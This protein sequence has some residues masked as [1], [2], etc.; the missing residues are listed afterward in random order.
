MCLHLNTVIDSKRKSLL[1]KLSVLK[2]F[3][4]C[5]WWWTAVAIYYWHRK[6][7]DFDFFKKWDLNIQI[8]LSFFE[9][10]WAKLTYQTKNTLYFDINWVKISFFW[11]DF[12][13]LE[14]CVDCRNFYL[15]WK[16]D[17]ILMKLV[18]IM[19]RGE[20]KDYVD[21]YYLF[22]DIKITLDQIYKFFKKLV[23]NYYENY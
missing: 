14:D 4:F 8:L 15:M 1:N 13:F 22:K 23:K 21:L 11:V 7:Q 2:D 6:S 3:W 9:K 17:L 10:L 18:A 20:F 16:V 5:L 12:A 19:Q